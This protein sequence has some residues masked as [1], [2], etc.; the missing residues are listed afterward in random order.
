MS[1]QAMKGA[2]T[3]AQNRKPAIHERGPN[4][5]SPRTSCRPTSTA[6]ATPNG[7]YTRKATLWRPIAFCIPHHSTAGGR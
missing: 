2:I 6:V 3:M 5:S 7:T 1:A 4:G